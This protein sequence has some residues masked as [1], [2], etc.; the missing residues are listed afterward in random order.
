MNLTFFFPSQNPI[1]NS[2]QGSNKLI[3]CANDTS[4]NTN[5]TILYFSVNI[6][7]Q[8]NNT[9]NTTNQT[10]ITPPIISLIYPN[11]NKIFYYNKIRFKFEVQDDSQISLCSLIIDNS[12]VLTNTSIQKNTE[13]EFK[14]KLNKGTHTWKIF[15]IDANQN[16][17]TS[18]ERTLKIKKES[19]E[20]KEFT[21]T[22][23]TTCGN[24][25]CEEWENKYTCPIDCKSK[26]TFTG[27]TI[28]LYQEKEQTPIIPIILIILII[29][30]FSIFLIILLIKTRKL[31]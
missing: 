7:N 3:V 25:I 10:D 23:Q 22:Q 12:I 4:G 17:A 29:G 19:T 11:N 31:S 2:Q 27:D 20:Y 5:F 21:Q 15:C 8:T 26:I 24:D 14:Y 6:T 30:V 28:K 16:S 9:N 13:Q 18:E 1:L